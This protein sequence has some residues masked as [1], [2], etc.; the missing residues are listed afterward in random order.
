MRVSRLANQRERAVFST[1]NHISLLN[2]RYMPFRPTTPPQT[3]MRPRRLNATFSAC[4]RTDG[5]RNYSRL[6][7][8][9]L[10]APQRCSQCGAGAAAMIAAPHYNR[11]Q[12]VKYKSSGYEVSTL[13]RSI[14]TCRCDRLNRPPRALSSI[15]ATSAANR[16]WRFLPSRFR[17]LAHITTSCRPSL[18][19]VPQVTALETRKLCLCYNSPEQVRCR[20][21]T[22]TTTPLSLPPLP[23]PPLLPPPHV[24]K[25]RLCCSGAG[26]AHAPYSHPPYS[27]MAAHMG[28]C[29]LSW[30][31]NRSWSS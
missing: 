13:A 27:A 21:L 5:R 11:D 22:T 3:Y 28:A 9:R 1:T 12:G 23:P 26:E 25:K 8:W 15:T 6:L 4:T 18:P 10:V 29:R 30:R 17:P 24:V 2:I 7:N 31:T 14:A 19:L 16:R 20:H